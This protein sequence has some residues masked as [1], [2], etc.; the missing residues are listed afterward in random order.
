MRQPRQP[1]HSTVLSCIREYSMRVYR[2]SI[3][4]CLRVVPIFYPDSD[5]FQR[6][7]IGKI[8]RA[9]LILR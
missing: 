2:Q 8:S 7:G 5:S 1:E 6:R 9:S 4:L 3:L